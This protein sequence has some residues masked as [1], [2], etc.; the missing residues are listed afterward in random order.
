M[1]IRAYLDGGQK[2]DGETIHLAGNTADVRAS[3]AST[4]GKDARTMPRRA[5]APFVS[6]I[7]ERQG[8]FCGCR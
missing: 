5:R 7:L 6:L 3:W 4:R 2:F 8:R 1:T